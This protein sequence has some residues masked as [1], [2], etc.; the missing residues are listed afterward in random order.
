VDIGQALPARQA[1]SIVSDDLLIVFLVLGLV[2]FVGF[3]A[4]LIYNRLVRSQVQTREAWSGID[5]QLRRRA[6][7]VPSLVETVA[8]YASHERG[9]FE[10]VTRARNVLENARGAAQSTAANQELSSALGRLFAVVENYPELKA[11]S[12]FQDLQ[13]RL[14]D[15]EEKIAYARQFYNRNV[16]EFNIRIRAVPDILVARMLRLERFEFFEAQEDTREDVR[17]RFP[18]RDVAAP[19]EA[20]PVEE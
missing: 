11:S 5:V 12:N 3:A 6:S 15:I 9:V 18:P 10:E 17:V 16:A 20:S 1:V 8:G 13:D 14:D 2:V 7:L 19:P 4:G